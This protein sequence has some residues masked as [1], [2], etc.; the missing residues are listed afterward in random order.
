MKTISLNRPEST[1]IV[2]TADNGFIVTRFFTNGEDETVLVSSVIEEHYVNDT[3]PDFEA[4]QRLLW[5]ILNH[6][7]I[8]NNKHFRKRIEIEVMNQGKEGN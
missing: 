6:L 1:V 3:E 4:V 8:Y 2:E 7:E 5:Q